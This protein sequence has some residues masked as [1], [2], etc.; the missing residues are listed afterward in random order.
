MKYYVNKKLYIYQIIY[1]CS[2]GIAH[3]TTA[4]FTYITV[5]SSHNIIHLRSLVEIQ[6][7]FVRFS[8]VKHVL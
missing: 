3:F 6:G 4:Y 5:V 8:E 2:K 1:Y 7:N